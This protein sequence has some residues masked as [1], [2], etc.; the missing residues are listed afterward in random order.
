M[1]TLAR[2]HAAWARTC[3][4]GRPLTRRAAPLLRWRRDCRAAQDPRGGGTRTAHH[5]ARL[6]RSCACCR[7]PTYRTVPAPGRARSQGICWGAS[8]LSLFLAPASHRQ[9]GFSVWTALHTARAVRLTDMSVVPASTPPGL[10]TTHQQ[11][12]GYPR[13]E[14]VREKGRGALDFLFCGACSRENKPCAAQTRVD[15]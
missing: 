7:T 1:M 13:A 15:R 6:P 12:G 3:K 11:G 10:D 8:Q 14:T 2:T 9:T 5:R 4:T